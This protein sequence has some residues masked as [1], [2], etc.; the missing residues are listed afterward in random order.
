MW[1]AGEWYNDGGKQFG[2]S[3]RNRL[4]TTPGW[5]GYNRDTLKTYGSIVTLFP[6]QLRYLNADCSHYQAVASLPNELAMPLP[7]P[8]RP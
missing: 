7:R 4:V 1:A 6:P 5:Q 2:V 8:R 3:A